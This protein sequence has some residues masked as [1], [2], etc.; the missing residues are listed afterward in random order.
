MKFILLINK[1][2]YPKGGDAISTI[3]TGKLLKKYGNEVFFWGMKHKNNPEY[4]YENLFVDEIDYNTRVNYLQQIKVALKIF[5]SLEAKRKIENLLKFVKFD[6]IHLNNFAHQISPSILPV[7]KKYKIPMVMTMR[8]Y[9]LVCPSY[10]M[11]SKGLPCEKCKNGKYYW[12]FINKC[13]KNS[14]LKSLV[15]TIE[16]YL[17]H[18]ILHI[19]ELIDIFISPSKFMLKK[20]KEMGFN[21]KPIVYLPNFVWIN[22]YK[23]EFYPKSDYIVY[24]G[25]LSKEK[26]LFTLLEAV[27]QIKK[28]N[29]KLIG[30]GPLEEKLKAKVKNEKISN[31][32]FI[33]F[34]IG[35][36]LQKILKNSLFIVLPS[37]CYENNPRSIIESF[38][39]GKPVI[40]ANIGGIPELVID[41]ITGFLFEPRNVDDLAEKIAKMLSNK[42]RIIEM[43]KNARKFVEI[44]FNP[45]RHYKMLMEIY[46]MA[47]SLNQG[48]NV[49]IETYNY[50]IK[51]P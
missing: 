17:H 5:Y 33:G 20:V 16:M 18:K 23:P 40:G 41:G 19:Y 1:F 42:K 4:K 34:K 10:S 28:V 31:V 13:T 11:L 21:K 30:R 45:E 35:K 50:E 46:D 8:D 15:N 25:R 22:E 49:K 36:E 44:N 39:I 6:I 37:E 48:K 32:E 7:I 38:A 51:F 43:G 12:C 3:N 14:Y 47:R 24:L 27:K 9:K 29:L 2:L 26:G